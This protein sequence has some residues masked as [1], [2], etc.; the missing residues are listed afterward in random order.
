MRFVSLKLF[1]LT[2]ITCVVCDIGKAGITFSKIYFRP[3]VS[4]LPRKTKKNSQRD[5]LYSYFY[6]LFSS[7]WCAPL[8][9]SFLLSDC[10]FQTF[11]MLFCSV[12]DAK[13][14]CLGQEK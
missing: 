5:R 13:S 4:T 6:S 3:L 1:P 7:S 12:P 9:F 14:Q 10:E 11:A 2:T 8:T